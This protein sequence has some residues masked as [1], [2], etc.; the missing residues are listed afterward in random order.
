MTV[1][2]RTYYYEFE[3]SLI[4]VTPRIWRRFQIRRNCTFHELHDTIQKACGWLDYHLYEF[5]ECT[6]DEPYERGEWIACSPFME[7]WEP[8]EVI[9]SATQIRLDDHFP[10]GRDVK[11]IYVYDF[12]DNWRHLVEMKQV[13]Q[14]QGTRRRHM[15]GGERAFPPE[16]CGSLTGYEECVRAASMPRAEVC[17]MEDSAVRDDLLQLKEWLGDWEPEHFDP[18]AAARAFSR[19]VR[20]PDPYD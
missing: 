7:P 20:Y 9:P 11:A 2:T 5:R 4:G 15:L 3:V 14:L 19:P 1:P 10:T 8:D 16:D 17:R 6:G 13:V 18:A 12:G